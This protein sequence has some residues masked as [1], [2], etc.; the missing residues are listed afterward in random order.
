MTPIIILILNYLYYYKIIKKNNHKDYNAIGLNIF[1]LF[2]K[3][4]NFEQNIIFGNIDFK[5]N[6]FNP[7]S[8][9]HFNGNEATR[10]LLI[11]NHLNLLDCV[12]I[13][14]F[15]STYYSDYMPVYIMSDAV[16]KMP[17]YGNWVNKHCILIKNN[18]KYDKKIIEDKCKYLYDKN[19]KYIFVLFPEGCLKNKHNIIRN[20]NWCKKN[21]IKTFSN[22]INPRKTGFDLILDNFKP[23]KL[24]LTSITYA[25]DLVNIKSQNFYNLLTLKL[26]KK[27]YIYACDISDYIKDTNSPNDILTDSIIYRIWKK[28]DILQTNIINKI[29]KNKYINK[30][31]KFSFI[32]LFLLVYFLYTLLV[33]KNCFC[34]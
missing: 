8:F 17:M 30:G 15:I 3:M 22:L 2:S 19:K 1:N 27:C 10:I 7:K 4:L 11:S 12:N 9:S 13:Q 24:I 16:K 32:Y 6:I 18:I 14:K 29:I 25:D 5:L 23:Q 31:Y 26:A 21:N 34:L 20:N 28:H 33:K